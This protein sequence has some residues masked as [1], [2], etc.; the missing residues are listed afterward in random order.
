MQAT[1]DDPLA[2]EVITVDSED[3]DPRH[4]QVSSSGDFGLRRLNPLIQQAVPL[5]PEPVEASRPL[6]E[7]VGP[8]VH[9]AKVEEG[10]PIL[11]RVLP[12]VKPGAIEESSPHS[13][14]SPEI[15]LVAKKPLEI[16]VGLSR[17]FCS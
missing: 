17:E 15:P 1:R 8:V 7:V 3:E 6:Q 13:A 2:P 4:H 11:E 12:N 5:A 9:P 10:E 14:A 16:Q